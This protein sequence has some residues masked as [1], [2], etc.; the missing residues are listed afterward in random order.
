MTAPAFALTTA[1]GDPTRIAIAVTG[2]I[3]VTTAAEFVAAVDAVDGPRPLIVDLSGLLYLDSAG[4][5]ALDDLLARQA[6]VIVLSPESPIRTAA[7]LMG[8]PCHDTVDAA[9]VAHPRG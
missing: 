2:E 3:D 1:T 6:I 5:V 4:F 7:A 8:L 9:R